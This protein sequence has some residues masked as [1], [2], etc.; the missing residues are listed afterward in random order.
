MTVADLLEKLGGI[1]PE[2]V[3]LDPPPGTAKEKDVLAVERREGRHCELVDGVL[4]E[5]AVGL[6]ESLLAMWIGHLLQGFLVQQ[7]LGILAGAD[8]ALRLMPGLVRI[9]DISFIS[10]SQFP[11]RELPKKPIPDL[12]PDLAVEVLS[13][14][15]TKGEMQRKVREYFLSG[16]RL[17]WLVDPRKRTVR[18]YTAPDQSELLG[19]NQTLEGGDVLPGLNLQLT[20]LFSRLSRKPARKK[21]SRE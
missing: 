17:V 7:D 12:S 6:E 5:K 4:V 15:N 13:P 9:P 20:E 18:V 10:W 14:S 11:N 8:G 16:T 21:R 3:R 1:P 2:R 19:E